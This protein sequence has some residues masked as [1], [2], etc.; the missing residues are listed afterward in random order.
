[1]AI[2]QKELILMQ[3]LY[4]TQDPSSTVTIKRKRRRINN[5]IKINND[6]ELVDLNKKQLH[7]ELEPVEKIKPKK[8]LVE[9]EPVEKIKSKKSLAEEEP[10]EQKKR[11]EEFKEEPS[12][13]R[14][15]HTRKPN[16]IVLF[17][18]AVFDWF[19][20]FGPM[21]RAIGSG[22]GKTAKETWKI[23]IVTVL[24]GV[25]ILLLAGLIYV[26]IGHSYDML[27][28]T[29]MRGTAAIVFVGVW[30]IA[31][32]Y[33]SVLIDINSYKGKKS[34][35]P[36]WIGFF[37][38]F[39]FVLVSNYRAWNDNQLG[40]IIGICTPIYLLVM[41]KVLQSQF[42][43]P[44]SK[45]K[46]KKD[47]RK[48]KWKWNWRKSKRTKRDEI[49]GQASENGQ[50]GQSSGQVSGDG[51]NG[52][53]SGQVSGDGQNGRS[54]GQV[55]GDGQN[56]QS[57][58]QVSG[59]GQNGRS[60]G[61]A[62]GNG[63]NGQ[64]SGQVSENGQN[65]QS[66]GQ[67]SGNGQNG[68]SS[69]QVSGDGQNGQSSGQVSGDGRNGQ[70]SGQASG[71]GRNGQSSGQVSGGGQNGQ[72]SG[73]VSENGQTRQRKRKK[74]GQKKSGSEQV[75]EVM[76]ELFNTQDLKEADMETRIQMAKQFLI[77][78]RE[79][80]GT[81]HKVR[82]T[83]EIFGLKKHRVEKIRKELKEQFKVES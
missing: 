28:S 77:R 79:K 29:G 66:S 73:Q 1:M 74:S 36:V 18:Y 56:G 12:W 47:K 55:S 22:I 38:G 30:E 6:N 10:V 9:E 25:N 39:G 76:N 61:Q 34:P 52:Q 78:Y 11:I 69:G 26:S 57:S 58:G 24:I 23:L 71:D 40:Q 51:Q 8:S 83:A 37:M 81:F 60:S 27:L 54:S 33:C 13:V 14:R 59:D 45:D 31:F 3:Q 48:W 62:S 64:S 44:S 63:R 2:F 53:S 72:S 42:I 19:S 35:L 4:Q 67:A 43:S 70:S 80:F 7:K 17:L 50:N 32:I 82:D 41:K 20:D 49:S 75:M 68:Q 21:F 46:D 15:G 5:R 16:A 65:G